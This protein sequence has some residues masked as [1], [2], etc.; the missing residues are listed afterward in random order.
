MH[1]NKTSSLSIPMRS[2][3]PMIVNIV[4]VSEFVQFAQWFATQKVVREHKTQKAF[5]ESIGVCQDTLTDWKHRP[6]FWPLV[7]RFIVE[8]MKEK[9][10]DVI[11]GLY[12]N[13]IKN[14]KASDVESYLRL[15]G[16]IN[17][18]KK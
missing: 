2:D 15:A 12:K 17:L 13:A 3:F 10:P 7:Q 9:V 11:D 18:N 4:N 16:L 8:Q 1:E 6:E 5:A 14:G